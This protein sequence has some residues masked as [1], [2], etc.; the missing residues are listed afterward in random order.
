M[1]RKRI[2]K[3]RVGREDESHAWHMVFQ[4]GRDHHHELLAFGLNSQAAI[5]A[6]APGAWARF[7][8]LFLRRM[9]A[10]ER[11]FAVPWALQKFGEPRNVDSVLRRAV[12]AAIGTRP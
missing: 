9:L 11:R 12:A 2:A 3:R 1:A 5:E 8:G 6:A 4:C 7:G 10:N